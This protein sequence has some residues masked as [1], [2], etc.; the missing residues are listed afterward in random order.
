M[1][2]MHQ[3]VSIQRDTQYTETLTERLQRSCRSQSEIKKRR[4]Y[5]AT[6]V[7]FALETNF[8]SAKSLSSVSSLRKPG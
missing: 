2:K 7:A 1:N 5:I 8:I 6:G 3:R 4:T